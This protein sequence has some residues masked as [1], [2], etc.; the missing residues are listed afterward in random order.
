MSRLTSNGSMAPSW[1][2]PQDATTAVDAQF[3]PT[4]SS[5]LEDAYISHPILGHE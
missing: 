2:Y 1:R 5:K 4:K 3:F